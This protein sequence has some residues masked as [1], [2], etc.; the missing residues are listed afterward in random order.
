VASGGDV[1]IG[2]DWARKKHTTFASYVFRFG[3]L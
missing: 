2:D 3:G 1:K